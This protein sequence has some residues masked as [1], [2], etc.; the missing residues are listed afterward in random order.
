MRLLVAGNTEVCEETH[1][2]AALTLCQGV[3]KVICK[4][5]K[6]ALGGAVETTCHNLGIAYR[7]KG[8]YDKILY[9]G[10][11]GGD[12]SYIPGQ[13]PILSNMLWVPE[14]LVKTELL[15]DL[16]D[17]RIYDEDKCRRCPTLPDRHDTDICD[18]CPAY[19]GRIQAYKK[20]DVYGKPM[21]GLPLGAGKEIREICKVI[22]KYLDIR[23]KPIFQSK[24]KFIGKLKDYQVKAVDEMAS[25]Q[26]SGIL[27]SAPRSGKT[28]MS[29]AIIC[30]I[31]YKTL[32][33][34][35]Q[36]DLLKQAIS[37][38][39]QF[40]TAV[41]HN[42]IGICKKLEDFKKY[43]I[44][45]ATY[46]SF[47]SPGGK[48]MLQRIQHMFGTLV[49]DEVHNVGAEKFSQV[50]NTLSCT[51]KFGLT[52]EVERKDNRHWVVY[53]LLGDIKARTTAETL[54]PKVYLHTI[55]LSPVN[56]YRTWVHGTNWI[57]ESPERNKAILR[58]VVKDIDSGRHLLIPVIRVMHATALTEAINRL[59]PGTAI[60]FTGKSDREKV[61]K[62]AR[63][64]E[65]KVVVGIRSIV[66]TGINVPI[67][68]TL[69]VVTPISNPPKLYQEL[70]RISTP[71]EN[72]PKPILRHWLSGWGPETG[73]L[74][75]CV[76]S[77]HQHCDIPKVTEEE[78]AK[79]LY[80]R[81][82]S[83]GGQRNPFGDTD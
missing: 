1:V 77:Y 11:K 47:L 52:A 31:G 2:R 14:K 30:K 20:V 9:I 5:H 44:C 35:S 50:V 19:S 15:K 18:P 48:Q 62:L 23:P 13:T 26:K 10:K 69:Y 51:F 76:K 16:L 29:L 25:G 79:A 58:Q 70:K 71:L 82:R 8:R 28:I 21:V 55:N 27:E 49:I 83:V 34:A 22:P 38:A 61:L 6:T 65:V 67:W 33:L 39:K 68:D 43:D 42:A 46:Q 81:S 41:K 53:K 73:C 57:A 75:T 74:R 56:Q 59:R 40:T 66:S 24:T 32:F 17:R 36:V 63:S 72:K 3:T 4:D 7:S 64:G 54:R 78:L 12:F 80:G 45:L 37:E 60:S